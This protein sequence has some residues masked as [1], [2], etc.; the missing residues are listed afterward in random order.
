VIKKILNILHPALKPIVTWYLSKDRSYRYKGIQ[1]TVFAGVFHPGFF[2]STT[3]LLDYLGKKNLQKKR[4][5][6]L[7]AG[8]GLI[9]I[10]CQ[11]KGALVTASDINTKALDNVKA[12][13]LLNNSVVAIVKSDLFENLNPN[14]FDWIVINPPYYPKEAKTDAERAW[15]CGVDFEFFQ[16]LFDQLHQ[17][18]TTTPEILM[19]LS[20]DCEVKKIKSLANNSELILVQAHKKK[21]WGEWNYIFK[22]KSV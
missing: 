14:D 5:L 13:C 16:K 8:T 9:S 20:E 6:E 15:Y 22:I 1:L 4:L 10:F 2:F 17:R 12:N 21:T 11:K 7:G 19:I 3:V 18:L